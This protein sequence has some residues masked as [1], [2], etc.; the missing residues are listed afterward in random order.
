M[1]S[2]ASSFCLPAAS[3]EEISELKVIAILFFFFF[4]FIFVFQNPKATM[5][6]KRK[7]PLSMPRPEKKQRKAIDLETKMVIKLHEGGRKANDSYSYATG[8]FQQF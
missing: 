8:Q 2:C 4:F 5:L 6:N 3:S 1:L 7:I